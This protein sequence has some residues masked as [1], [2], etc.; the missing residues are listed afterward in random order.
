MWTLIPLFDTMFSSLKHLTICC[1]R[2][3]IETLI[4]QRYTIKRIIKVTWDI[5]S[6]LLHVSRTRYV[7][8]EKEDVQKL[9]L[10]YNVLEKFFQHVGGSNHHKM[11][12]YIILPKHQDYFS[13]FSAPNVY[14]VDYRSS[15]GRSSCARCALYVSLEQMLSPTHDLR[16]TEG[17]GRIH[18]Y[19]PVVDSSS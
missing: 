9:Y 18:T 10:H 14:N 11:H 7:M 6:E 2:G 19:P 12:C 13:L 16:I 3:N 1:L 17:A 8:Y 5:K 4:R 15:L